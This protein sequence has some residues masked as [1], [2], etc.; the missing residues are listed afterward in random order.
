MSLAKAFCLI[1]SNPKILKRSAHIR[2]IIVLYVHYANSDPFTRISFFFKV[3]PCSLNKAWPLCFSIVV[4]VKGLYPTYWLA[5]LSLCTD[6]SWSAL[7]QT[8]NQILDCPSA[9]FS[10]SAR[11]LVRCEPQTVPVCLWCSVTL[12]LGIISKWPELVWHPNNDELLIQWLEYKR[13][14][15]NTVLK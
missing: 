5:L 6:S 4:A 7:H 14:Y 10:S 8:G 3:I 12:Y 13:Q 15:L 9:C 1:N 2:W 11:T